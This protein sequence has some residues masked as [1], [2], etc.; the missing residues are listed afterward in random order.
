[1]SRT[2]Y[3]VFASDIFVETF[4]TPYAAESRRRELATHNKAARLLALNPDTHEW[5]EWLRMGPSSGWYDVARENVPLRL[6]SLD[7][8]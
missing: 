6:L 2:R 1:M 7:K 3:F 8:P 5:R 4:S